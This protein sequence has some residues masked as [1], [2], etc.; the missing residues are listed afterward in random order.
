MY[1]L[2]SFKKSSFLFFI[3]CLILIF[4]LIT[5]HQNKIKNETF[6]VTS[7]Q[8]YFDNL[9]SNF[10]NY[11][12]L[13]ITDLHSMEF[14]KNNS[15]LISSIDKL[16]PDIIFV[17]G[18]MFSSSEFKKEDDTYDRNYDEKN[19]VGFN[20]LKNLSSK[21]KII[22]SVGNHEEGIDAIF[23]GYEWN[24]RDRTVD[25][26]YNR[27][28]NTLEKLGVTFVDNSYTA[29]SKGNESINIY[30]IYYY[31]LN[32]YAKKLAPADISALTFLNSVD[33]NKFNILISH[34]PKGAEILKDKN[35][36]LVISGHVHGGVIR[37]FDTA[38]LDPARKLFPKY[39]KG[40]YQVSNSKLYVSTGLGNSKFIRINNT[41]E[42]NLIT[43][44][45]K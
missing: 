3:L 16:N 1:K 26:A 22:Y 20:L 35:F 23:N 25:N 18:D 31:S 7:N 15:D 42:I 38:I 5:I 41:P 12:I 10:F 29:I 28:I 14:G 17:T 19:L 34:D 8:I 2:K 27:Y 44:K 37:L 32:T 39:S 40:V 24:L 4:I 13:Q 45:S 6:K 9:P 30:G 11:K 36:D 43:L 33:K 21:Y